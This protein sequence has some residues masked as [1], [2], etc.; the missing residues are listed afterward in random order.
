MRLRINDIPMTLEAGAKNLR[1]A[2]AEILCVPP[3]SVLSVDVL[4]K[5]LDARRNR[6]PFFVYAVVVTVPDSI[7]IPDSRDRRI[8]LEADQAFL[9]TPQ[10]RPIRTRKRPVVVGSGPSGLFAALVLA[11]SGLP[12]LL[13]ERGKAVAERIRDVQAFWEKGEFHPESHVHF[14]EG[15]AGT[16]SDGKL[17]S[18]VKN[19][20]TAWV[21]KILVEMGAPRNILIDAKPHIGTDRLRRIVVRMRQELQDLG[22]EI[23]F[24]ASMTDVI[25]QRGGVEGIVINGGEHLRA[26]QI[27]LAIG[28][29]ADDSYRMLHDRGVQ[30]A[31]KPFAAGL[32]IEH[33]QALID[34]IQYGPWA[35]SAELPPAEYALAVRIPDLDRAVYTFCMCPGGQVIGCSA[36]EKGVVTNGMSFSRRDGTFANSAVVVNIRPEDFAGTSLSPLSGLQFRRRW[37]AGAY[38]LGGCHYFAPA[39]RLVDFLKGRPTQGGMETSFLPG[40]VPAPLQRALPGFAAEALKRGLTA[41]NEKMPGFLTGEAVLIG[42]ETRTSSPVRIVRGADGQSVTVRGLFP[43]GEGAGYAGGIV[44]SALDGI[45]AAELLLESLA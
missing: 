36:R 38:A 22:C 37:E 20:L 33:P 23:R 26:E 2:A 5:S 13:V 15:G 24:E 11:R 12:V 29:S 4:R 30:L 27:I 32:R 8:S 35:G 19:P 42:V 44:S 10:T 45:R 34:E 9:G 40:V 7:G 31:P 6:P 14:G 39:Q 16:F 28:Q 21:K 18:R 43:C 17:T 25:V 41:F 3:E 1:E